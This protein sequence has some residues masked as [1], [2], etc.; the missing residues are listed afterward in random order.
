MWSSTSYH[1]AKLLVVFWHIL[2]LFRVFL[3]II[4]SDPT[5]ASVLMWHDPYFLKL[6]AYVSQEKMGLISKDSLS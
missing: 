1:V 2:F 3:A 5:L 4:C 6:R